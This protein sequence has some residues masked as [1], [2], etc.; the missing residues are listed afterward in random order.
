M[1]DGQPNPP[2]AKTMRYEITGEVTS[3][4]GS[5]LFAVEAGSPAEAIVVFERDGGEFISEE[6]EVM[7]FGSPAVTNTPG[8]KDDG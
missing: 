4:Q 1:T 7:D 3:A 6:I 2:E 8:G 5:Q